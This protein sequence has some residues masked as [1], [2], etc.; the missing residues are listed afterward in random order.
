MH[1]FII[2]V[3]GS[4]SSVFILLMRSVDKESWSLV[5]LDFSESNA[6]DTVSSFTVENSKEVDTDILDV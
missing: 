4:I 6:L 3:S 5:A 2:K 1:W